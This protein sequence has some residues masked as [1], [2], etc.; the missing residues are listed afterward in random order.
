ME[1]RTKVI[2]GIIAALMTGLLVFAWI[3][4]GVG[5][6][7]SVIAVV[8][9]LVI[10]VG[11]FGLIVAAGYFL[12]IYE[13]K[14]NARQE[15]YKDIVKESKLNRMPNLGRLYTTGDRDHLPIRLGRIVGFASRQNYD[16][17]TIA[18]KQLYHAESIFRVRREYYNP[19]LDMF[20]S[21]MPKVI[22]RC[23]Q[24]L[25]DTLQ[26]DI[27]MQCTALVKH[28]HYYYPNTIHLN[29]K[30]IDET[31]FNES[32][33]YINMDIVRLAHPL[34]MKGMGVTRFDRKELEGMHGI[35]MVRGKK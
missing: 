19:L 26:G 27:N 24:H 6:F 10:W 17:D 23:P 28:G 29:F 18:E 31:I 11:F 16:T 5:G 9:R 13:K 35:D 33:R 8:L 1:T 25:H 34:I 14:I 32:L 3:R 4:G 20:G 22:V 21:F 15:V 2:I 30:S 12:F 7:F